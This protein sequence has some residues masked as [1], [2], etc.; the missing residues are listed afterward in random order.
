VCFEA[1]RFDELR[2]VWKKL[3]GSGKITYQ[4]KD[5]DIRIS[6]FLQVCMLPFQIEQIYLDEKAEKDPVSQ[7][8]LKALPNIPIETVRDKKALIKHFFRCPIPLDR[9]KT[10]PHH[11]F[12]GRRLK[13]CPGTS[14]HIC[15]GYYV[16][17]AINELPDGLLLL[18]PPRIPQQPLP[19]PLHQL[20]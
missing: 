14:N 2:S 19:H 13:P 6:D 20:G 5:F 15:C 8:I 9:E 1:L 10:S 12:Y 16:I 7:T 17:N 11:P 3:S 4:G 18:C